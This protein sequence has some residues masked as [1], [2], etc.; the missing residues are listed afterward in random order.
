MK[1]FIE[2]TDIDDQDYPGPVWVS[3]KDIL[4]FC[5]LVDLD[6]NRKGARLTLADGS[7]LD[8]SELTEDIVG[9]L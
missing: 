6:G 3:K 4:C 2:L 8:V 9:L 7:K 1:E 5:G